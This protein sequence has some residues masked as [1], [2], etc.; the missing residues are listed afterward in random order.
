MHTAYANGDGQVPAVVNIDA[1]TYCS[2]EPDPI[3]ACPSAYELDRAG[4]GG[5][6]VYASEC[7]G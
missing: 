6:H 3:K 2:D 7:V 5:F 4:L 1:V